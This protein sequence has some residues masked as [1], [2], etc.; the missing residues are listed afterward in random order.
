MTPRYA[1][2]EQVRGGRLTVASDLYSLGVVLHELL[3]GE[4][5]YAL[6]RGSRA[7]YEQAILESDLRVPSR[8]A[9]TQ[10]AAAARSSTPQSIARALRG[11]LDAVLMRA[12]APE[13]EAR[14]ASAAALR[15]DLE[16]WL[17][18]RPVSAVPPSRTY[19]LQKFVA[20]NRL[21]VAVSA[22]AALALVALSVV[23]TVQAQRAERSAAEARAEAARA[24]ATKEFL[25][26]TYASAD[27]TLR[28]GRDATAK[29]LLIEAEKQ[30]DTKLKGQPDLQA[31]VLGTVQVMWDRLGDVERAQ[32][33][34][35]RRADVLL[36]SDDRMA[37]AASVLSSAET[38]IKRR[39]FDDVERHIV[40]VESLMGDD[41]MT[42]QMRARL[43]YVKG[44][45]AGE[46]GDTANA[47]EN[48]NLSVQESRRSG[49]RRM[50]FLGL[51]SR[52][53][54]R[55]LNAGDDELRRDI[56]EAE[57]LLPSL[58]A[59]PVEALG[60]RFQLTIARYILG[61]YVGGWREMQRIVYEMDQL[62]GKENPASLNERT[63]WL[64]YCLRLGESGLAR[65][66]L[67]DAASSGGRS[68]LREYER[69]PQWHFLVA[70][71][72]M[73]DR[74][75]SA[76]MS[77]LNVATRLVAD[78]GQRDVGAAQLEV[79]QSRLTLLRAELELWRGRPAAARALL[80]SA[81]TQ[82][83]D[84]LLDDA[85]AR[86]WVLGLAARSAGQ[87]A[88]SVGELRRA[89]QVA[90]DLLGSAHP[91]VALIRVEIARSGAMQGSGM[92]DEQLMS[93]MKR[94]AP[95]L[96]SAFTSAHPAVAL[97]A[98]LEPILFRDDPAQFFAVRRRLAAVPSNVM[99]M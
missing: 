65:V 91:D 14:Y 9:V 35:D 18:G 88:R 87:A 59:T 16:R 31:E 48:M 73:A 39:A 93:L 85:Y 33:A 83:P 26:S 97:V 75:W 58:D 34:A 98:D 5:P 11:D 53:F 61:D 66:W 15:E 44:A 80:S 37:A 30:L 54:V 24:N 78:I 77:H 71:V 64:R 40:R 7:E 45:S 51:V 94:A 10:E 36:S 70:R 82:G 50:L 12:L 79:L 84:Q 95:V 17:E 29:E 52:I 69:D 1:S 19:A 92:S 41:E 81:E 56:A 72:Y 47:L 43:A 8:T 20:R 96:R 22:A 76:A 46:R 32:T 62:Y 55:R 42:P 74:D 23:A 2:P 38:A 89:E 28:G 86:Y 49:D 63:Y 67:R 99:L 27:P 57:S 4:T 21:A 6:R 60:N 3:T 90:V 25:I 13:P 68:V